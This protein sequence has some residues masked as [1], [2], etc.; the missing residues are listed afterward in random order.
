M[1]E[2]E[3]EGPEPTEDDVLDYAIAQELLGW[4]IVRDGEGCFLWFQDETGDSRD[5]EF[6]SSRDALDPVYF[7]L[8]R[9]GLGAEFIGN[10]KTELAR[11]DIPIAPLSVHSAHP[12]LQVIAA[13][14]VF[15]IWRPEWVE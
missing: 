1:G 11:E 15:G 13:L 8:R 12:R 2:E 4:E 9:K 7:H 10:L 5:C 14:K 3:V 6:C